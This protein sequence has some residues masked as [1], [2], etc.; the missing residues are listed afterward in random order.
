MC[1]CSMQWLGEGE[2]LH[3]LQHTET[4]HLTQPFRVEGRQLLLDGGKT[5]PRHPYRRQAVRLL[6]Q[7]WI[8]GQFQ[9]AVGN[10]LRA[11]E[12]CPTVHTN[13]EELVRGE[14]LGEHPV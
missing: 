11:T 12:H 3:G 14:S 1:T 10:E 9:L 4:A 13:V 6:H 8:P 5:S 7:P 2:R